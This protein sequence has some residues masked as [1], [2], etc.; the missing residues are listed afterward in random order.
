MQRMMRSTLLVVVLGLALTA[1]GKDKKKRCDALADHLEK[2]SEKSGG[3]SNRANDYQMC[4]DSFSD[5]QIDC[6]MKA[7]SNTDVVG[8]AK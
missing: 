6:M 8:C 7:E 2:V 1:C 4:M 5:K 3:T